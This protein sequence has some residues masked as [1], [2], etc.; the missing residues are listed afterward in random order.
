MTATQTQIRRDTETNLDSA[1][2]ALAE[3]AYDVT[4]KRLRL[5]D[6]STTGAILTPNAFDVQ[7]QAFTFAVAGGSA[8]ALTLTLT[9]SPPS[10]AQP[11]TLLFR[12]SNTNTGAATINVNGLGAKNIY[13]ISSGS[14]VA[15]GAGDII[16]GGLYVAFYDGV[17]FQLL[18]IY[19][20]ITSVSQGQL[21][22]STG[23]FSLGVSTANFIN[24]GSGPA[25]YVTLGSSVSYAAMPGGEYGFT[26]Q[27]YTGAGGAVGGWILASV[28]ST[29]VTGGTPFAYSG[30]AQ[31][32]TIFGFQRYV[33][34][35][36]PFN[37]G[38]GEA[39][40]FIFALVNGA[41]DIVGHYA[42]DVPPWAYNGP[43]KI[44]SDYQCPISGKK[45]REVIKK[46]TPEQI[47]NGSRIEKIKE[48][49]SD[50]LK[51]ADM[52]LI[53][54]PFG[55][56]DGHTVVMID[57]VSDKVKRLIEYQNAGDVDLISG[58]LTKGQLV[59]DNEKVSRKCPNGVHVCAAKYK[60]KR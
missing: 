2:P 34:S 59:I 8:N 3:L 26:P 36:P 24:V 12:A 19:S 32:I 55:N 48:E 15:L 42:A 1:I 31:G 60:A 54:H 58:M 51:N 14:I 41:G 13:K 27:A 20:G 33:T 5:G 52:G 35:S 28:S 39:G 43:T 11:L 57:P 10:Y 17:Q 50:D 4:K 30:S 7:Q 46:K 25:G 38:D 47:M 18:G 21:N 22:T 56:T 53:P 6:G 44:R 37:L 29:A 45:Y 9:P 40:G 23:T 16:S 49:I